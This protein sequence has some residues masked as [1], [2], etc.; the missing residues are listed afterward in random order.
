[1]L[2]EVPAALS[3]FVGMITERSKWSQC[4]I[5]FITG[6]LSPMSE[7]CLNNL[8]LVQQE[9]PIQKESPLGPMLLWQLFSRPH[10]GALKLACAF[11]ALNLG[12]YATALT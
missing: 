2:F 11:L 3:A 10:F 8:S 6:D 4:T 7:G 1:M 9:I 5:K 12:H